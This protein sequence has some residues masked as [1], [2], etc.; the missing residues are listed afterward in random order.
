MENALRKLSIAGK[1]RRGPG[2]G[3]RR[4]FCQGRFDGLQEQHGGILVLI[5]VGDIFRGLAG[6]NLTG[7]TF[8]R[9]LHQRV[10]GSGGFT[11]IHQLDGVDVVGIHRHLHVKAA[12]TQFNG[13]GIYPGHI[14]VRFG[15]L[16]SGGCGVRALFFSGAEH[17]HQKRDHQNG[18]YEKDSG[19]DYFFHMQHDDFGFGTH[20]LTPLEQRPGLWVLRARSVTAIL[21][22]II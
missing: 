9:G 3:L 16:G 2:S 20:T 5:L 12:V 22:N 7:Q 1:E 4:C 13:G 18:K 6:I 19:I 17:H 11:E 8:Q 14:P 10:H 21:Y 15:G